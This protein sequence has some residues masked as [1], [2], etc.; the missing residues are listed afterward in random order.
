MK[1]EEI[2]LQTWDFPEREPIETID[3]EGYGKFNY[4][5]EKNLRTSKEGINILVK[6]TYNEY[7][8]LLSADNGIE[9]I[10]FCTR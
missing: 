9:N 10:Y 5:Y 8:Q 6:F 1:A 7:G 4:T 2:N 3:L